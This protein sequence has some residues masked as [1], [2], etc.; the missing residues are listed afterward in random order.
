MANRGIS[1]RP[2]GT[3]MNLLN[4]V[5]KEHDGG[6][7]L[8]Q[9]GI[10]AQALLL[11]MLQTAE[12]RTAQNRSITSQ[13]GEI[14]EFVRATHLQ[15]RV[16]ANPELYMRVTDIIVGS[17]EF[18]WCRS[19]QQLRVHLGMADA[20]T[21]D[22]EP[23]QYLRLVH[24]SGWTYWR[25]P[26][27]SEPLKLK[28]HL[29]LEGV[30]AVLYP[31][32]DNLFN[33]LLSTRFYPPVSTTFMVNQLKDLVQDAA[34]ILRSYSEEL[35][36]DF[37]RAISVI[38]LTADLRDEQRWS[39]SCRLRYFGGMFVNP[40]NIPVCGVVEAMIHEYYH[41][42]LWQWWAYDDDYS[43]SEEVV[44]VSPMTGNTRSVSVMMQALL[45]Y[46]SILNFYIAY[47]EL[48]GTS[49]KWIYNRIQNLRNAIPS[50]YRLLE[51][52]CKAHTSP[53]RFLR[54][55]FDWHLAFNGGAEGILQELSACET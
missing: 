14:T 20:S 23:G 7:G 36:D 38:G 55:V 34:A 43:I 4:V 28:A 13:L 45:I 21:L 48:G 24:T 47:Y 52:A 26:G 11:D 50:L 25:Q 37:N 9:L 16:C 5:L 10:R 53:H 8:H 30:H 32:R 18:A 3:A 12:A 44:V 15:G 39:F 51:E 46:T 2:T 1:L 6:E 35:Y 19:M 41:Q 22:I 42:R 54:A 27:R 31:P 17:D 40:Y 33:D 29:N 49:R